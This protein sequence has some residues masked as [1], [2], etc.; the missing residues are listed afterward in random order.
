MQPLGII[1]EKFNDYKDSSF[2][3]S[4]FVTKIISKQTEYLIKDKVNKENKKIF[5][6]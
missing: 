4:S 6:G 3:I 1:F 5:Y 2:Y